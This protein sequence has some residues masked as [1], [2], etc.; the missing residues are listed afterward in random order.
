MTPYWIALGGGIILTALSQA[1]LK[2]GA[3]GK[4]KILHSFLN[5]STLAGYS[6]FLVVVLLNVLAMKRI[7]LRTMTAASSLTYVLTLALGHWLLRER[8]SLHMVVGV[9][10]IFAGVVVYSV[11]GV[12]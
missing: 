10:L 6:L 9:I 1:L 8:V 5:P 11:S 4:R 7:P 12:L 2:S 3:R